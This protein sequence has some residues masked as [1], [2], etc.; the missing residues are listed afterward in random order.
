[1]FPFA[2]IIATTCCLLV[3]C[4]V[5]DTQP[6]G[7]RIAQFDNT[8]VFGDGNAKYLWSITD[9]RL[10]EYEGLKESS[11]SREVLFCGL[12]GLISIEE[13]KYL[14]A[15]KEKGLVGRL[16]SDD[17]DDDANDDIWEIKDVEFYCM[18]SPLTLCNS[19][20]IRKR[21][22]T[23][24]YI[25]SSGFYYCETRS[26]A[27][28]M[29]G[30]NET[31][32]DF[33]ANGWMLK[34]AQPYLLPDHWYVKA[35]FGDVSC[36]T[37]AFEGCSLM[38]ALLTRTNVQRYGVR[39]SARGADGLGNCANTIEIE[40]ILTSKDRTASF[41]QIRGS[42]PLVWNEGSE[43]ETSTDKTVNQ[44]CFVK[45]L[46]WLKKRYSCGEQ[47]SSNQIVYLNL[48]E[49]ASKHREAKLAETFEKICH[50]NSV[51]I[52]TFPFNSQL[53]HGGSM[54]WQQKILN[55]VVKNQDIGF[56]LMQSNKVMQRQNGVV[57]AN[58][59]DC[60]DRTASAQSVLLSAHLLGMLI[61]VMD[62]NDLYGIVLSQL[63]YC[64]NDQWMKSADAV[65]LHYSGS[66][67][68]KHDLYKHG[69]QTTTG[70]ITDHLKSV[71]RA[72]QYN[73]WDSEKQR[74]YRLIFG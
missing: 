9:Q 44:S 64:I 16:N 15:I 70:V 42:I 10:I 3:Q 50:E 65:S 36:T 73:F 30:Q 45:H 41:V 66:G 48:L 74:A 47:A 38:V 33:V 19:S 27:S 17:D 25:L 53:L 37:L 62:S 2:T 12:L 39:Y 54:E 71:K 4:A 49:D 58:C 24:K 63:I 31:D 14:V 43:I 69:H 23:V 1:M 72:W 5:V 13:Q 29:S 67:A 8:I 52:S 26:L 55:K 46:E 40:Q 11:F 22:A 6:K 59:L 21:L 7:L 32:S 57:R 56:T 34:S 61:K 28:R 60:M 20:A 51:S 68:H 18:S 35:I